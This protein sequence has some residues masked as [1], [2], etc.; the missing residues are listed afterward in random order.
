MSKSDAMIETLQQYDLHIEMM[1]TRMLQAREAAQRAIRF[2]LTKDST[3]ICVFAA[4]MDRV[5]EI[6][7][8]KQ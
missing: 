3:I 6:L 8:G 5:I 4:D 1:R 7:E 2:S